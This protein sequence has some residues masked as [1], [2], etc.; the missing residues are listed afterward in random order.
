MISELEKKV[1]E[2][3]LIIEELIFNYFLKNLRKKDLQ[4][5]TSLIS[6]DKFTFNKKVKLFCDLVTMTKMDKA[7]FKVYAK[8]NNDFKN[9]DILNPAYFQNIKKY[10]AF[11]INTYSTVSDSNSQQE[12]L[13]SATNRLSNNIVRLTQIY[14]EKH[15]IYYQKRAKNIFSR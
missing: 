11:L 13:F 7:K 10:H 14:T 5:V 3:T 4:T 2:N 12:K 1:R 9:N 8:I 6:K 15:E